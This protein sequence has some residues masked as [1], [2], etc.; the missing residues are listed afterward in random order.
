MMEGDGWGD[1]PAAVEIGGGS[2][3]AHQTG[4]AVI[5][6]K[7]P[8]EPTMRK[9]RSEREQ[10]KPKAENLTKLALESELPMEEL[11]AGV[12]E[13]VEA[14]AAELGLTIIR[15]VMEAEIEGKVGRW[16]RQPIRRHGDRKS[17]RL[18]SSHIPLS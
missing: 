13:D 9:Y 5:T 15:R 17:T 7:Q 10:A 6:N 1:V 2:P 11:I 3:S 18:N 16:G 8:G 14:L 4:W 12:R